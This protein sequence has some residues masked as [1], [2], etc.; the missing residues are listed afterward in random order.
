MVEIDPAYYAKGAL[1]Q[2]YSRGGSTSFANRFEL[3]RSLRLQCRTVW[4]PRSHHSAMDQG[5][6]IV[7]MGILRQDVYPCQMH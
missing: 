3:H 5:L 1:H 7:L 2:S 6:L 4:F